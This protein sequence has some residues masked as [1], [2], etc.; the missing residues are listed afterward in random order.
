M[1]EQ[2]KLIKK[3]ERFTTWEGMPIIYEDGEVGPNLYVSLE[4]DGTEFIDLEYHD[5]L[6]DARD[7]ARDQSFQFDIPYVEGK[8]IENGEEEEQIQEQLQK[9]Y[10]Q[11]QMDLMYQLSQ[12]DLSYEEIMK[13]INNI[14]SAGVAG[15]DY[16]SPEEQEFRDSSRA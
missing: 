3:G 15:I 10:D 13:V 5:E 16:D 7:F 1:S 4:F 9:R 11:T 2:E 14:D 12:T 8:M 6:E